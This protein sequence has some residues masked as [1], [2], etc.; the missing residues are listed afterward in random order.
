NIL[1]APNECWLLCMP[2]F[3]VGGVSIIL[4]SLLYGS[5]IFFMPNFIEEDVRHLLSVDSDVVAASLVP[6][7]HKRLLKD[8]KFSV[9]ENFQAILLGGGPVSNQ[10]IETSLER[11]IPIITSYGMTE[12]CA[13]IA[14]N[15]LSGIPDDK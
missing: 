8:R 10:L 11:N 7:M 14:A 5:A 9:H 15:P 6:T 1:P 13:Q 2:L 12:T 4:R 3:H